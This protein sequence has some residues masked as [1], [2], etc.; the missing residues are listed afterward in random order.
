[1]SECDKRRINDDEESFGSRATRTYYYFLT[2]YLHLPNFPDSSF[3]C[4]LSE[5]KY[6]VCNYQGNKIQRS[7]PELEQQL[8]LYF[9]ISNSSRSFGNTLQVCLD[10]FSCQGIWSFLVFRKVKIVVF[11]FGNSFFRWV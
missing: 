7:M 10:L 11:S 9:R 8:K 1:M 6:S 5:L 4:S 2:R 3:G